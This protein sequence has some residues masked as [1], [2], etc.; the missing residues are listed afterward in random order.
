MIESLNERTSENY[1]N[2]HENKQTNLFKSKL[3]FIMGG[4]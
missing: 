3:L 2:Q 4:G 1:K